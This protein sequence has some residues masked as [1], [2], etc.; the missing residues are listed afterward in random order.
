MSIQDSAYRSA[1]PEDGVEMANNT[2]YRVVLEGIKSEIETPDSFAIKYG[3]LTSTPVT[4][5]KFML[6]NMPKTILETKSAAK[7]RGAL[8]L[9]EEAGGI[10]L[11]EDFDMESAPKVEISEEEP[12]I[13]TADEKTCLKCGFPL[14]EGDEY[15]QFCHT[16][17]VEK[18]SHK[19]KSVLKAG[20]GGNLVEPK[21]LVIYVMALLVLLLLAALTR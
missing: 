1:G 17:L 13:A 8:E 3:I 15:C 16:P 20:G 7:A 18:K 2:I 4:R 21:R 9:I 14:K 5:V 12:T 11:I 10:G 19:I 6:R